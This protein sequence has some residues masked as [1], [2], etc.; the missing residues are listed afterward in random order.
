M[1]SKT[2]ALSLG[3]L[4]VTAGMAYTITQ[5][6]AFGTSSRDGN[7]SQNMAQELAGKLGK[8]EDEVKNA[9]SSLREEHRAEAKNNFE[10]RLSEAVAE[11]KITEDQK[12]LIL[13]KHEELRAQFSAEKEQRESHRQE[14][15]DWAKANGIDME[16][17][18]EFGLAG[19]PKGGAQAGMKR[20]GK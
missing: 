15:Q 16:S 4:A 3:A 14:M 5:A 20:M 7:R 2:I 12:Q 6:Q 10:A 9:F 13:A 18:M 19:G 11:G 8:S 17:M 1:K